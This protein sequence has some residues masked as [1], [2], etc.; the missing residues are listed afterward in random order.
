[1]EI[2]EAT[3]QMLIWKMFKLKFK[4]PT[5]TIWRIKRH[6]FSPRA[7]ISRG[8]PFLWCGQTSW[9]IV[10]LYETGDGNTP[11]LLT[12]PWGNGGITQAATAREPCELALTS[13]ALPVLSPEWWLSSLRTDSL[14]HLWING[15]RT[16]CW[17]KKTP[18]NTDPVI[19][20]FLSPAN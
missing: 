20:A 7:N 18:T 3:L 19:C 8:S 12:R 10:W 9:I 6:W 17:N 16:C 5:I 14:W 13:A 11:D 4:K 1:M 15:V 2:R